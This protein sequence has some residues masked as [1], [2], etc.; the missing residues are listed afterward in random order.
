M[1]AADVKAQLGGS[2]S[3]PLQN[4]NVPETGVPDMCTLS[5]LHVSSIRVLYPFTLSAAILSFMRSLPHFPLSNYSQDVLCGRETEP[6]WASFLL[7]LLVR[8]LQE[9]AILYN[10]RRRFL[11]ES[12]Y[13]Y[14]GD[15]CIAVSLHTCL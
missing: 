6:M 13:T 12:P 9:P 8:C 11:N 4:L 14:T 3:F 10:L 7:R 1:G 15:I 2:S 5:Y